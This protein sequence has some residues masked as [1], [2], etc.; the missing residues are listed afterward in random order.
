MIIQDNWTTLQLNRELTDLQLTRQKLREL[1]D[2]QLNR[3]KL[4][5]PYN[6]N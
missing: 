6:Y 4:N 2:L 1:T 3:Q 5:I